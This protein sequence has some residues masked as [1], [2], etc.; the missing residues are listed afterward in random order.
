MVVAPSKVEPHLQQ[1]ASN[2]M[3]G[4]LGLG[5]ILGALL[6]AVMVQLL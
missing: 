6:S 3:V 4:V 5:L 2:L 1:T